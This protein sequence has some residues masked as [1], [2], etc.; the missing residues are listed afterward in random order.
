MKSSRRGLY[1]GGYEIIGRAVGGDRVSGRG[2]G[3][4]ERVGSVGWSV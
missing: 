1:E 2:W 4:W 3:Q